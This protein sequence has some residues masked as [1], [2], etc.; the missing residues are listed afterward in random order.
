ML[1][2]A[3]LGVISVIAGS[4]CAQSAP[5]ASPP[6]SSAVTIESPKPVVAMEEPKPGDH[7]TFETHDEIT[8]KIS[9]TRENVVTEVTPTNISVRVTI[10]GKPNDGLNV[11]DRSWNLVESPPWRFSPNDGS[12][13]R[14]PLR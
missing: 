3:V 12:G 6:S 11:Y 14:S 2:Y 1:R 9:A 10:V 4:A 13:I 7:W 5:P 8:G